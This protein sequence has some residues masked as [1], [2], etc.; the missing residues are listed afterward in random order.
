MLRFL[1]FYGVKHYLL[2]C[3]RPDIAFAVCKLS[4]YTS[5][6]GT[7][8]W[9]AVNRVFGYLKRTINFGLFYS[10]F[11]TVLEGYSDASWITSAS[12]NKSTSGWIF[13]IAG[14]AISWASK[15]QTCI[16]HS[17][18]ESEFIAFVSA[19][20]LIGLFRR[21]NYNGVQSCKGS[22]GLKKFYSNA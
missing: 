2:H 8:H 11:P 4:R 22:L 14:R 1:Y 7:A 18:I 10:E 5:N 19:S 16:A 21:Q 15:K 17:T 3:T 13:T 12:D 20:L 6:P 9:K